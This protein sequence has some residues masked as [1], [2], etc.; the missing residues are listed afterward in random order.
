MKRYGQRLVMLA[1]IMF[2]LM[3][4]SA[5]AGTGFYTEAFYEYYGS[6][7]NDDV[8]T[9][10]DDITYSA[11]AKSTQGDFTLFIYVSDNPCLQKDIDVDIDQ[12]ASTFVPSQAFH[13]AGADKE[14]YST[15]TLTPGNYNVCFYMEDADSPSTTDVSTLTLEVL[16][17]DPQLINFASTYYMLVNDT[18]NTVVI[19]NLDNN[20]DDSPGESHSFS[21]LSNSDPS[22]ATC[23]V[24]AGDLLCTPQTVGTTTMQL[25]VE[26]QYGATDT[27][28]FDVK[29]NP[30]TQT[31][32]PP[33][34]QGLT[35][36]YTY[37]AKNGLGS[38]FSVDLDNY[39]V[40]PDND[41]LSY[42]FA[43]SSALIDCAQSGSSLS[44]DYIS[45]G[46]IGN[47]T[48]SVT[49]DD[50][51]E[52]S[53]EIIHIEIIN[54]STGGG[55]SGGNTSTQ[56]Q[57]IISAPNSAIVGSDVTF[58]GN[59]SIASS[60]SSIVDYDWT[61]DGSSYSG[62]TVVRQFTTTGTYDVEL[63]VTDDSGNQD[64]DTTTIDIH[65]PNVVGLEVEYIRIDGEKHDPY[66]QTNQVLSVKRGQKLPIKVKVVAHSDIEDV[67]ISSKIA[68]YQYSQ[69]EQDKIFHMTD[70]FDLDKNRWET[71]EMELEVP[72]KVATGD[73]KLRIY[74]EDK[75]SNGYVKEYNLDIDGVD[76]RNA[77]QITDAYLS[78]SNEVLPGRAVSA[79]VKVHNLGDKPLDD[80]T[81]RVEVPSLN[82]QDTETLDEL[83]VDEKETFERT[84]LRF[85]KDT[86][87]GD[88]VVVYTVEFD[89]YEKTTFSD[90][91]T[92][93]D[94]GGV[95]TEGKSVIEVPGSKQITIGSDG[96]IYPISITNNGRSSKT[97]QLSATQIN[98]WGSY[99]FDPSS[100]LVVEAGESRTVYLHVSADDGL[101]QG[102]KEFQ[103]DVDMDDELKQIPLS[104]ALIN[105]SGSST[106]SSSD[107]NDLLFI[108]LS[109]IVLGTILAAIGY[110]LYKAYYT[111]EDGLDDD[112]EEV[113]H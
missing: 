64:T 10:G 106:N 45:S 86:Q 88:Y 94:G 62:S 21:L 109:V 22:I 35:T 52:N 110:G 92:I 9:R 33:Y 47:A 23:S 28:Q 96:A 85:P 30:Q 20:V 18:S 71:R 84:I 56:L 8:V 82:I 58:H 81:L 65:K 13:E 70:T 34:F 76:E 63:T 112:D 69:Y 17:K 40:D 107:V 73:V 29:V 31:N 54:T 83:D 3:A 60:N 2:I 78:P 68:G 49:V 32:N 105:P 50:G 77:V 99:R 25:E 75:N 38:I 15:T 39:G 74:V 42:S 6:S 59:D 7:I 79:L 61:I 89:E 1:M 113:R 51:Q 91:V 87:P 72:L 16:N 108:I 14:T 55:S 111:P 53:S 4:G 95:L 97:Y 26:D 43:E 27:V 12:K 41:S 102:V 104:A 36:H 90:T 37:D 93:L 98:S 5:F 66:D 67:Q 24:Q 101:E 57:A 100:L 46:N 11:Y 19:D 48:V 80:V 103:L 44:C